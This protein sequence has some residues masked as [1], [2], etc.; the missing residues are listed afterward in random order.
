MTWAT[1]EDLMEAQYADLYPDF[2]YNA[3]PLETTSTI[4]ERRQAAVTGIDNILREFGSNDSDP[5]HIMSFNTGWFSI[6]IPRDQ[7]DRLRDLA[8]YIQAF[9]TLK[10]LPNKQAADVPAAEDIVL[11]SLE[12][13]PNHA[14]PSKF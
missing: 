11:E 12:D 1:A 13:E 14:P 6:Q 5:S 7:E 8:S 3:V 10:L 9:H 2:S 4:D